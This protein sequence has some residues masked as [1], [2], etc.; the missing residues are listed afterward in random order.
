M[1]ESTAN[2]RPAQPE[3]I[4][5]DRRFD[6][7][8]RRQAFVLTGQRASAEDLVQDTYERALRTPIVGPA[9]ERAVMAWLKRI[10][11]NRFID[12]KRHERCLAASIVWDELAL[13]SQPANDVGERVPRWRT[14]S[15]GDLESLVER[16]SPIHRDILRR[17]RSGQKT[18]TMAAEL[19]IDSSTVATR[20][21]RARAHLRAMAAAGPVSAAPAPARRLRRGTQAE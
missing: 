14:V 9:N 17:H 6:R 15:D 3:P 20:L 8:L 4:W 5:L 2:R 11:H 13:E 12:E 19:G 1:S 18:E 10:I 7:A 16:L 21:F